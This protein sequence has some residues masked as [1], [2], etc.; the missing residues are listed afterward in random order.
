MQ[1][2]REARIAIQSIAGIPNPKG[3]WGVL[4]HSALEQLEQADPDSEWPPKPAIVPAGASG[5]PSIFARLLVQAAESQVGI[6]EI[7]GNNNGPDIRKYQGATDE[8]PGSWAWC[9]AL[10][11]WLVLEAIKKCPPSAM[12]HGPAGIFKRPTTAGA[13]DFRR[14]A[15]EQE[16]KGVTMFRPKG[17]ELALPGDIMIFGE[18]SHIGLSRDFERNRVVKMIEGNTGDDG[19]RDGDGVYR[20][21]RRSSM[22]QAII[23]FA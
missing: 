20:K 7:G 1:T 9:A 12:P 14:W 15:R 18:L 13:W 3:V 16:G 17:N 6:R 5:E 8:R 21:D 2:A 4:T 22:F 10:Q 11:C 23:R 19:G